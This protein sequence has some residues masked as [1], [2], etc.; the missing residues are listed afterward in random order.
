MDGHYRF[1]GLVVIGGRLL[2]VCFI[3]RILR[4]RTIREFVVGVLFVPAGFTLLW[5]TVF[6]NTAY[7]LIKDKAGQF[8]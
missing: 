6:G 1:I 2:S 7:H 8:L 5:M 3:A 4:G